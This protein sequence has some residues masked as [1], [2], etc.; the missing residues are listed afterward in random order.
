LS[1]SKAVTL[2]VYLVPFKGSGEG[3]LL[4]LGGAEIR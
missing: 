3:A 1:A 2:R 4:E